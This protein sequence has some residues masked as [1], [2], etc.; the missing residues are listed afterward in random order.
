MEVVIQRKY[1]APVR[2]FVSPCLHCTHTPPPT[3]RH[4]VSARERPCARPTHGLRIRIALQGRYI[5]AVLV[6][7]AMA[8]SIQ[9]VCIPRQ[10]GLL[11]GG[12]SELMRRSPRRVD[13]EKPQ[14]TRD[15]NPTKTVRT[16]QATQR[17]KNH[18]Y[19]LTPPSKPLDHF[20]IQSQRKRC[21]G[22]AIGASCRVSRSVRSHGCG[23]VEVLVLFLIVDP[24]T[25]ESSS[26]SREQIVY[27]K[28]V[29]MYV[30]LHQ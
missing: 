1:V 22:S 2:R 21:L 27:V 13:K 5:S 10:P 12:E 30:W 17:K 18:T 23:G 26:N 19:L 20:T 3:P 6:V 16:M 11:I 15:R 25:V 9:H 14:L 8:L 4:R 24:S 28:S 7:T 29:K